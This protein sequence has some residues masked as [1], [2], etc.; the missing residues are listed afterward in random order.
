MNLPGTMRAWRIHGYGGPEAL[1]IDTM[2]VPRPAPGELLVKVAVAS[3]NPIDW[4]TREGHLKR[5]LPI[6]FPRILG[7]DCAGTVAVPSGEFQAGDRVLSVGEA[8]KD[9]GQAEYAL[10]PAASSARI[11][12][13]VPFEESIAFG[14][15]GTS[16]WIPLVELASVGPLMRVLVHGGAGGVGSVAVRPGALD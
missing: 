13:S 12:A 16:A 4:K 1:R 2:P 3:V 5:A 9:G 6:Q 8:G 7:R 15:A 11:P 14:I 10:V